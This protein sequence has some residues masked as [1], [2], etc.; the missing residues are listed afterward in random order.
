MEFRKVILVGNAYAV[1][2]PKKFLKILKTSGGDYVELFMAND[3][4]L[5]IR[6]HNA[7]DRRRF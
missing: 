2:M 7:N 3:K 1:T 6:K 5:V 4:T